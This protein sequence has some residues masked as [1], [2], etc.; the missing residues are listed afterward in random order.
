MVSVE[1]RYNMKEFIEKL[2]ARLK[3]KLGDVI[4]IIKELAGEHDEQ[5]EGEKI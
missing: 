1:S 4:N 2:I 5:M 3:Y